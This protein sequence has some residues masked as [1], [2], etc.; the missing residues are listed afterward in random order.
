MYCNCL[1]CRAHASQ[2]ACLME[3]Y[4]FKRKIRRKNNNNMMKCVSLFCIILFINVVFFY[5]FYVF[6]LYDFN[7][8]YG[9]TCFY[10]PFPLPHPPPSLIVPQ[11][12]RVQ[13]M[14]FDKLVIGFYSGFF[15]LYVHYMYFCCLMGRLTVS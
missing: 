10:L 15:I 2:S 6:S 8:V 7:T 11:M 5:H 3:F 4:I 13:L 12:L 9:E 1:T 14:P